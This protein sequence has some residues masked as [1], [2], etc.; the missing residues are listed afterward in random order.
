MVKRGWGTE[1]KGHYREASGL[2]DAH[3]KRG[4]SL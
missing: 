1:T 3:L 2:G 4:R